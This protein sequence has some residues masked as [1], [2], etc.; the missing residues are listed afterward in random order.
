MGTSIRYGTSRRRR[1]V[2][3]LRRKSPPPQDPFVG[4]AEATV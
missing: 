1:K 3:R 4:D 2:C